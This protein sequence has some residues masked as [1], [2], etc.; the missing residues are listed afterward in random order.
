MKNNQLLNI[1]IGI[2]IGY[3][4]FQGKGKANTTVVDVVPPRL[5]GNTTSTTMDLPALPIN[6]YKVP[7][8]MP[9]RV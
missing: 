1:G 2:A 9:K 4:L 6:G 3:V 5:P 8:K 7:L